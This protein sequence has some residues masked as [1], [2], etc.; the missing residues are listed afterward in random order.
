MSERGVLKDLKR[1]T[2]ISEPYDSNWERDYMLLLEDDPA[3][4]R[5]ERCRSLRIPYTRAD[6]SR[7]TYNPDFLV[8]RTDGSK[9]LH[10]VKGDHLVGGEDTRRKLTAGQEFCRNRGMT[11]K[12][13]TR[14]R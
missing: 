11:F 10:E 12:L 7:S 1:C 3:V 8:E 9:E 6:G 14:K 2:R 13:I 5:W 4:A